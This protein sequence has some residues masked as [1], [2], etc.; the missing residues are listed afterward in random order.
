MAAL[1]KRNASSVE[2]R[3]RET[4]A[5]ATVLVSRRAVALNKLAGPV[6]WSP[7]PALVLFWARGFIFAARGFMLESENELS[8]ATLERFGARFKSFQTDARSLS[9]SV[10]FRFGS[11]CSWFGFT[12]VSESETDAR[13]FPK[14]P[15][16]KRKLRTQPTKAQSGSNGKLLFSVWKISSFGGPPMSH[17]DSPTHAARQSLA[18]SLTL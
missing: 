12:F 17:Y 18:G 11:R 4:T 5:H 6:R 2:H 13:L 3:W 14:A 10:Y 7:R 8:R 1:R 15:M 9:K 16:P